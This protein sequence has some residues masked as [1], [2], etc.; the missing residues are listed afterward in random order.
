MRI[1]VSWFVSG[2]ADQAVTLFGWLSR[3]KRKRLWKSLGKWCPTE[4]EANAARHRIE[5]AEEKIRRRFPNV[6][7]PP[8]ERK[9]QKS[10]KK[11]RRPRKRARI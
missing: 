11:H 10:A 1:L 8:L 3:P 2:E 6:S 7:W 5:K 9:R 4:K